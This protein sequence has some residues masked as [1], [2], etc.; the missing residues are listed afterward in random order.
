M[1][2]YLFTLIPFFLRYFLSLFSC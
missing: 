2:A 1:R